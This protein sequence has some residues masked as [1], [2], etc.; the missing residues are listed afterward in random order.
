MFNYSNVQLFKCSIVQM[1]NY[2]NVQ[3]F[4][5]SR[6]KINSLSP[7]FPIS[8]IPYFLNLSEVSYLLFSYLLFSPINYFP[9]Y[10]FPIN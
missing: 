9:I 8:L 2:S 7:D 4:K 6:F 10:Y 5:C 3:L 1:F